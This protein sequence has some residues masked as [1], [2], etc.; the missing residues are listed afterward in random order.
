MLCPKCGASVPDEAQ[1]CTACG[2]EVSA[3]NIPRFSMKWYRF[4]VCFAF[5]FGVLICVHS[6]VTLLTG[7][8]YDGDAAL[9]YATFSGLRS[10][11]YAC[12]ALFALNAVLLGTASIRMLK[13]K[14]GAPTLLA[15]GYALT[16]VLALAYV[17]ASYVILK[18]SIDFADLFFP[19]AALPLFSS[20]FMLC[21]NAVYYRKRRALFVH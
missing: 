21:A 13:R 7:A 17:L 9:T 18:D 5:W 16:A 20:L 6:A 19:T 8:V 11:N 12:G 14:K 15:L 1:V 2:A 3:D 4:G 10:L